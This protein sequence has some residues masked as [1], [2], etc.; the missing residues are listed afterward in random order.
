MAGDWRGIPGNE[1]VLKELNAVLAGGGRAIE[2]VV[3]WCESLHSTP[4]GGYATWRGAGSVSRLRG[5]LF[6]SPARDL[7]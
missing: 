1:Y 3:A 6:R 4:T 5:E 2:F 7:Q